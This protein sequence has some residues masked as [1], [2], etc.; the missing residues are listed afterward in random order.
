MRFTARAV[1]HGQA[2]STIQL[3][4]LDEADVRQQLQARGLMVLSVGRAPQPLAGGRVALSA[5]QFAEELLALLQAGLNVT[6]AVEAQMEQAAS[7]SARM[8]L[9]R[10]LSRL[11][12]GQR[13][14]QALREQ[15][16]VFPPLLVG[17]V[18]AAEGTS[19]LPQSLSR[20]VEY[21]QRVDAVRHRVLSASIY[22]MI[23]LLVGGGVALF[24]VGY[25]VP[26]FASVYRGAGKSLPWASEMLLRWGELATNYPWLVLGGALILLGTL[27]GM[28]AWRWH[29]SG[30]LGLLRLLPGAAPRVEA[31]ELSRLYMT[32][33]MLL[34]GGIALHPALQLAGP[35]LTAER[36]AGLRQVGQAIEDG[37]PLSTALEQ[38]ALSTPMALRLIRVGERS[39]QLGDMLTRAAHFYD[40]DNA[41]WIER[42]TKTFE[43]VLMA[44]IGAV[45]GL[46]VLLLYMPIFDLAGSIQP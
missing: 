12:E 25:V 35:V 10:I 28:V 38:A 33:G 6:E 14:S 11:N 18:Q 27:V 32:L 23:L 2:I 37:L 26:R 29:Q 43:P 15:P 20:Y 39:G 30:V 7:E 42:F 34:E 24:L 8:I 31:F 41:R 21:E 16:E 13:L 45:V 22:P 5:P 19:D 44:A 40:K 46:I 9:N 1:D 4:A 3:D 17:I 36:Q